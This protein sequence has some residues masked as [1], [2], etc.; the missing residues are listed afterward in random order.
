[1]NMDKPKFLKRLILFVRRQ[2]RSYLWAIV[3]A[4]FSFI[5]CLYFLW[6][7]S[8]NIS[9]PT[10]VAC[11]DSGKLIPLKITIPNDHDICLTFD[12]Y[13][14]LFTPWTRVFIQ[15]PEECK[16]IKLVVNGRSSDELSEKLKS[17]IFQDKKDNYIH[18]ERNA[19]QR[20]FNLDSSGEFYLQYTLKGGLYRRS[21][22]SSFISILYIPVDANVSADDTLAQETEILLETPHRYILTSSIPDAQKIFVLKSGVNYAFHYRRKE[23]GI[24]IALENLSSTAFKDIMMLFLT[25]VFGFAFGTLLERWLEDKRKTHRT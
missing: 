3:I 13:Q 11:S 17:K 7:D 8:K 2:Q 23:T 6:P 16:N 22:A 21:Y 10:I 5:I 20:Y 4:V 12:L 14:L 15:R 24:F 18:V 25:T 9:A 19:I 1:M